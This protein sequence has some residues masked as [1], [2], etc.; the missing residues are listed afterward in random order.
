MEIKEYYVLIYQHT[1]VPKPLL[2]RGV[3]Y[4]KTAVLTFR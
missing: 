3:I 4:L 2:W 1:N